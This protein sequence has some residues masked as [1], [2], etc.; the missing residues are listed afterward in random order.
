MRPIAIDDPVAW[1][2][3]DQYVGQSVIRQRP[4]KTAYGIEI[5]FETKSPGNPRTF[6]GYLDGV[7]GKGIRCSHL[8]FTLL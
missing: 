1:M 4:V 8:Q 3:V 6:V 5:L 7:P 2:S